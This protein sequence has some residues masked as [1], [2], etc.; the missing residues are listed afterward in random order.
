MYKLA[1]FRKKLEKSKHYHTV[2]MFDDKP[3]KSRWINSHHA[4]SDAEDNL[5]KLEDLALAMP[6]DSPQYAYLL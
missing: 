2:I 1:E 5:N 6:E 3:F 4:L